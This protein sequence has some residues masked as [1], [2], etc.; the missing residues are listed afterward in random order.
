MGYYVHINV[1]FACDENGPVAELA[2]EE[3]INNDLCREAKWFL[4]DLSSR[5]G[6][7]PGPKGGLLTWG[8]VG[9]YTD[10]KVFVN[11]LVPFWKKLFSTECGICDFEH[12]LVF[13]ERE[14]S[15]K[16]TAFEIKLIYGEIQV[17]EHECPFAWMQF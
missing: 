5:T 13:V 6:D 4:E 8:M 17:I 16:A 14:Q 3:L 12:I 1:C 11:C 15:E 2:K 9:N 10:G 7:N